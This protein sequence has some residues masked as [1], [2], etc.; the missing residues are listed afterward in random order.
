MILYFVGFD[1]TVVNE[2]KTNKLEW[3]FAKKFWTTSILKILLEYLPF[4]PK[5]KLPSYK[6]LHK[7]LAYLE[8]IDKE[9]L[10]SYNFILARIADFMQ[11][12]M[13][14]LNLIRLVNK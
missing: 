2:V 9:A 13:H 4:G 1:N 10:K 11:L 5:G 3:S 14:K 6:M 12:S 7:F 8:A